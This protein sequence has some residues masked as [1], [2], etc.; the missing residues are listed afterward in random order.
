MIS[1]DFFSQAIASALAA[2]PFASNSSQAVSQ[3]T[4]QQSHQVS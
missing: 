2:T 1:Q 4:Y 3:A